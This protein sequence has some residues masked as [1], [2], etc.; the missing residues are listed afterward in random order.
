MANFDGNSTHTETIELQPVVRHP[1][2]TR[3]IIP[4]LPQ[5]RVGYTLE[6]FV[7]VQVDS[8]CSTNDDDTF[9]LAIILKVCNQIGEAFARQFKVHFYDKRNISC[10]QDNAILG[11]SYL[12]F[13][14]TAPVEQWT[15]GE[16]I[17]FV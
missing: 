13:Q 6:T 3:E 5:S 15:D 4:N 8:R 9:W 2:M 1:T 11:P 14:K 17:V 10:K 7:V 12:C 16:Q